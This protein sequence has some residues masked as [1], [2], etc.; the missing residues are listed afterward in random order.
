MTHNRSP[1]SVP[2]A[3]HR[4]TLAVGCGTR[5]MWVVAVVAA[6]AAA[7]HWLGQVP[8]DTRPS[9]DT[10]SRP[11]EP[12]EADQEVEQGARWAQT[13]RVD[14]YRAC[15]TLPGLVAAGCRKYV[16]AQKVK[17]IPPFLPSD[18]LH[19]AT[20]HDCQEAVRAH[21]NA[22]F[23]DLSE[24]GMGHSIAYLHSEVFE[25]R[26]D[27]CNNIDNLR[28]IEAVH[29]PLARIEA[30]LAH[31][32]AG[33]PLSG[34]ELTQLRRDHP[35]VESFRGDDLR[36]RYLALA[37]ELFRLVGGRERVFPLALPGTA[38]D[39][40]C[41]SLAQQVANHKKAF[42]EAVAAMARATKQGISAPEQA[43]MVM[44]QDQL[45]A[46]WT[47]AADNRLQ[48]GCSPLH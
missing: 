13:N 7:S 21:Y 26:L 25:P 41:E 16:E 45:L 12:T 40:Q 17:N 8:Y 33:Q 11:T 43:E 48:V 36:T 14:S 27:E 10:P 2:S 15:D 35:V 4:Q 9:P 44:R 29:E 39:A 5:L 34:D 31:V 22:L 1:D 28:I 19:M 18:W 42:H 38:R 20:T 37:D 3:R 30:M 47:Q 32:R 6:L 23:Q 24:S 46:A